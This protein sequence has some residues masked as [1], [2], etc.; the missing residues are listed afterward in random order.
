MFEPNALSS[1]DRPTNGKKRG[2]ARPALGPG[3]K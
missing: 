3:R 2:T 1:A